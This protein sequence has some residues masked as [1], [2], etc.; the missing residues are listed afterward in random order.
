MTKKFKPPVCPN[1]GYN[2]LDLFPDG[3]CNYQ[4]EKK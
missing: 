4:A 3:A 2:L 1:C